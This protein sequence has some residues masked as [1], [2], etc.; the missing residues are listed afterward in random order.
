M[1]NSIQF[2]PKAVD[3]KLE[4]QRRLAAAP[5]EHAEAL[6]VAFDL[7]EEAHRQGVL[8]TR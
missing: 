8:G 5:N 7:L 3:P 2:V 1:A 4:L 6:L